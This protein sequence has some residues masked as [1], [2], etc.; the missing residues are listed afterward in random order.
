MRPAISGMFDSEIRIWRPA[1]TKDSVGV[2]ERDYT[3]IAIV[4]CFINRPRG[5]E[6]ETGA[7]LAPS[8]GTRWYGLPTID[9]QPRDVCEVISGPEQGKLFE[10]NEPPVRPKNHHTQ[11]D[12]IEWNGTLP[13]ES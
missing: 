1:E 13:L 11:V 12:C 7:G 3:P 9:V 4:G 10:V 5:L 2:E 6:A 8:G